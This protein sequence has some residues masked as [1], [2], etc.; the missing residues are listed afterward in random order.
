LGTG[1]LAVIA[2]SLT[3]NGAHGADLILWASRVFTAAAVPS[4]RRR[5]PVL[6][7]RVR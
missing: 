4:Q 1:F 3:V 2:G 7:I 6:R 5:R